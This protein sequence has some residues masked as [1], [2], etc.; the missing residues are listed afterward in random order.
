M[1]FLYVISVKQISKY[2]NGKISFW[3]LNDAIIEF[4]QLA[5]RI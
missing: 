3:Y 2:Q 1:A 5:N 4:I